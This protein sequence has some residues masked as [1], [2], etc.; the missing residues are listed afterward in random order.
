MLPWRADLEG[1]LDEHVIDSALLRGNPLGDPHERPLWVYVP[2]GYDDEPGRRYP[3]IYVIQGYTGHLAMWRNRSPYRRPFIETADQVFAGG[4]A[5]PAIVV[6]VDAWT[7]YG[8]SQFVDSA[9]TGPYHS[10]LCDE[11]VPWVD[12]HYRTLAGRDHRGITGKSSGGFGAMITPMLRPDLFGGLA[13]HAGDTLYEYCYLPEFAKAT[14]HL[15]EYGGD[16]RRW[17]EGFR[18][19]VAFTD[20][21]DEVLLIVLGCSAAFSPGPDGVPELPFDPET[22]ALRPQ[23]WQ[24]WLDW[25]PV[26]MVP[27]HAE[28]LRSMRAIWIDAGKRDEFYLDLGAQ[29]FHKALLAHGVG[30]DAVHFELFDAGHGA[31][32]YRYPLSLA[33][34]AERLSA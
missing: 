26:R 20:P 14:R 32:D 25:D 18:S 23:A 15:R 29:A 27:E 11:V 28:A 33:W 30:E 1:R 12:E 2:P 8:G 22:G 5:P 6:Y 13:T 4:S 7:A 24:R 3:S 31:I 19:R 34:L 16:I 17:W 21:A 10:Y 9:G